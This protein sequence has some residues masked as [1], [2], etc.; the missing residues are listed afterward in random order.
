MSEC[1]SAKVI[2]AEN[3]ANLGE[4]YTLFNKSVPHILESIFSSLDYDSFMTCHNVSKDW[5]EVL[6]TES[7]QQIAKKLLKEK[8]VNEEKLCEA[9]SKGDVEEIKHLL[10]KLAELKGLHFIMPHC[11]ETKMW[12]NY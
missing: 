2:M 8:K 3:N 11:T 10:S 4:F 1:N 7:Y 5:N 9:S 6:S 12:P